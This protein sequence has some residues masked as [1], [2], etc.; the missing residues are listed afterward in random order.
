M[1]QELAAIFV[2]VPTIRNK[3]KGRE[4]AINTLC[5]YLVHSSQRGQSE[6][7]MRLN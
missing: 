6:L 3:A 7:K 4:A 1:S 5:L 2:N